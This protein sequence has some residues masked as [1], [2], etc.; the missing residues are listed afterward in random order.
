MNPN[1]LRIRIILCLLD[2]YCGLQRASFS[3]THGIQVIFRSSNES[4][5]SSAEIEVVK[6]SRRSLLRWQGRESF[7]PVGFRG[8][9]ARL[10]DFS[11]SDFVVRVLDLVVS[12][13]F[14]ATQ[15]IITAHSCYSAIFHAFFSKYQRWQP[16]IVP[17]QR[18]VFRASRITV[19]RVKFSVDHFW[20][21]FLPL[22]H[23]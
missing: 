14:G 16:E 7:C 8:S 19:S 18:R 23:E 21:I 3:L 15:S 1:S 10:D 5:H 22:D 20:R 12:E 2:R 4:V 13:R 6:S 17:V 9:L 11:G